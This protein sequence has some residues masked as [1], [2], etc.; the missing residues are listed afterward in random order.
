MR[1]V[2]SGESYV[3]NLQ[4]FGYYWSGTSSEMDELGAY[5]LYFRSTV[6]GDGIDPATD[7]NRA[8]GRSVRLV[9]DIR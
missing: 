2:S 1:S 3:G 7:D 9:R 6:Y 4:K 8:T 5:F